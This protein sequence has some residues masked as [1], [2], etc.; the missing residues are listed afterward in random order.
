MAE[1]S[2]FGFPVCFIIPLT[3]KLFD[4]SSLFPVVGST[5]VYVAFKV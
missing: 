5:K 4:S 2:I 1:L 3:T